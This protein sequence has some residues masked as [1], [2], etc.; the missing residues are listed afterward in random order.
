MNGR[1]VLFISLLGFLVLAFGWGVAQA[2]ISIDVN[3]T[4]KPGGS[5][6]VAI[7]KFKE[8]VEKESDGRMKVKMFMSGQLGGEKAQ[9]ELLKQNQTQMAL[10]GGSYLNWCAK[11]FDPITIPFY[12]TNW[13][14][15]QA[16]MSG[17]LGQ[18]IRELSAEKGNLVL[19]DVQKRGPR[20]TTSNRKIVEPEDIKGLKIR[21]PPF[22]IWVDVWSSLGAQCTVIPPTEIYLAMKTGQVDAHE[23]SLVSPYSRKLWEVQKY[24]IL[25][26]HIHFPWHW[27]ASKQW[28]DK[29]EAK[30]QELIRKAVK[31]AVQ[32]GNA[33]EDEKDAFYV[34][35][36]K[37]KGMEFITPNRAAIR[38]AAW[39]AVMKHVNNLNPEVA[40]EIEKVCK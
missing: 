31:A 33:I 5:E 38:K 32:V 29:L 19:F 15:V 28:F 7:K 17:P 26:G 4:M 6:E 39:P 16:Y 20:H 8:I 22:P 10:S 27:L 34:K 37:A 9:V 14:C 23:N 30:D 36:L 35:E 21:M 1:K 11:D 12:L 24:V 3:C 18:K 2:T 13:E 40:K 25:T